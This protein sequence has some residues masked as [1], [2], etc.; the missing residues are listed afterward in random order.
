M[1]M[2]ISLGLTNV[3]VVITFCKFSPWSDAP[4]EDAAEKNALGGLSLDGFLSEV[5]TPNLLRFP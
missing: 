2:I 1:K 4:Y 3:I 5:C